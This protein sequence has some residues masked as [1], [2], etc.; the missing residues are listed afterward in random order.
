LRNIANTSG[1][2]CFWH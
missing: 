2:F 1:S